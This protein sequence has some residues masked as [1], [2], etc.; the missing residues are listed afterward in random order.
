MCLEPWEE[1]TG[2][3]AEVPAGE[4]SRQEYQSYPSLSPRSA[5]HGL[6]QPVRVSLDTAACEVGNKHHH[7]WLGN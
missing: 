1:V 3:S 7:G 2:Q 4:G 6:E 5:R